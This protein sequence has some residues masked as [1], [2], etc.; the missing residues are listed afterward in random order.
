MPNLPSDGLVR[1]FLAYF[2]PDKY[3]RLLRTE[4]LAVALADAEV[5]ALRNDTAENRH[6]VKSL[7]VAATAVRALEMVAPQADPS[8]LDPDFREHFRSRA[9]N[10]TSEDLRAF[11]ASL[12]AGEL[13]AP[14]TIS[15][16]AINAAAD[17][18]RRDA[19]MIVNLCRFR[20]TI[21]GEPYV[22]VLN[23]D[24][25]PLD[26]YSIKLATL[27]SLQG[28]G[29]VGLARLAG[30]Q[31]TVSGTVEA[32]YYSRTLLITS[33]QGSAKLKLGKAILTDVGRQIARVVGAD[34]V[35]GYFEFCA[36]E[37]RKSAGIRIEEIAA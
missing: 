10:I 5:N 6:T 37:W 9:E 25:V 1:T 28:M 4:K 8:E 22:V 18:D 36:D 19:E 14:G 13:N 31:L 33:T 21:G 12:L 35:Q 27:E 32:S 23:P 34:P 15:K 3:L 30:Y 2:L 11:M 16:R 26:R 20:W 29:I 17:M 24:G 7:R